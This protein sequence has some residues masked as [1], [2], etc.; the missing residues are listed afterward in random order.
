MKCFRMIS[1]GL[2]LVNVFVYSQELK[3][4]ALPQPQ[5][6]GGKPLMQALMERKSSREYNP[7]KLS[8]QVLSNLLWAG[9]GFNRPEEGKRTSPTAMNKQEIDVYVIMADGAFLY[10]AKTNA[11]VPVVSEDIRE[12]TGGQ[13]FVKDAPVNLVFVA[14]ISK[15]GGPDAMKEIYAAMDAAY[16]SENVYLFCA[17]EGLA[18]VVRAWFDKA[19]LEKAL[20]LKSTQKAVLTQTVGWP[21]GK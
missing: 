11:L 3:P 6:T 1:I 2:I 16:V 15:M 17:S 10:D 14:D 20:N 19:V 4:V 5:T 21:K 8:M 13:P 9:C 7:D 12:K 18:T